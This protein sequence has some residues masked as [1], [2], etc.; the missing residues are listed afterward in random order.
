[1]SI[2][3]IAAAALLMAAPETPDAT[4]AP[5]AETA[6]EPVA[7]PTPAPEPAAEPTA[8]PVVEEDQIVVTAKPLATPGDPL[9][10]VNAK[11][12]EI[13]QSVDKAVVGPVA[14]AYRDE[15]PHPI[16]RGMHNFLYNLGEPVVFVNF[17]LQL[18]VGKAFET[19]GRF[20][21]N[22]TIGGAGLFDV[23]KKKPFH[24]PH[25]SNG[26]AYTMGFYGI[27]PGAYLYL[28]F[29][30]PTTVRDLTGRLMD[31]SF[32][33]FAV[34]KP[35]NELIYTVPAGAL[36]VLDDRA[37]FDDQLQ[38]IRASDDP[39]AAERDYYMTNRQAEIDALRGK[40]AKKKPE[41][42]PASGE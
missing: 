41:E 4:A 24:L 40:P 13:I 11:S 21:I 35:F 7:A 37:E 28:P 3:A 8:E 19:A 34:G 32:L 25:R 1:M 30:G 16:R 42:P 22:S 26:F 31:L 38:K 10:Q 20:A 9:E 12:F 23:A 36:N 33:P 27:K 2:T 5:A 29:I 39:Y 18:K 15:V 17:L 6:P 14:L